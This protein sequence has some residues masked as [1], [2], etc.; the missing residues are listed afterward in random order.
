MEIALANPRGFC[1]GVDRAIKIVEEALAKYGSPLYV[2]HEIVHN[3]FIINDFRSR[4]VVFINELCEV[5]DQSVVIF[6]AH[7]VA[8]K[9]YEEAKQRG[10]NTIDAS[11]PLVKKVHHQVAKLSAEGHDIV[12]IGKAGHAEVLGI[13]GHMDYRSGNHCYLVETKEDAQQ[14][15]VS[16]RVNLAYVTQTTLSVDDTKD[17]IHQLHRRFENIIGPAE[18]DICY[19][20]QNR[21]QAVKNLADESDL[22][23]VVGSK[24]SS[25]SNS[26]K[27]LAERMG[28]PA[29]LIDGPEEIKPEWLINSKV[30]GI[31]AGASAP[32]ELVQRVI[33]YFRC[34]KPTDIREVSAVQESVSFRLPRLPKSKAS[35]VL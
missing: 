5:P 17:I 19:A 6:S 14:L 33:E 8:Q 32:E 27:S 30:V 10:I 26:L 29:Y 12:I 25:N 9:V 15:E 3:R 34:Y 28:V 21:Q 13:E 16:N 35:S 18:A 23:L 24:H 2:R 7:G 22:V 31:T 1:A 20:T 11:C 4:G